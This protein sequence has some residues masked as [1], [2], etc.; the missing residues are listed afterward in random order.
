MA[1]I[2]YNAFLS[3]VVVGLCTNKVYSNYPMNVTNQPI[4][5]YERHLP[6]QQL[7]CI[8]MIMSESELHY[9]QSGYEEICGTFFI[10][11]PDQLISIE[12]ENTTADCDNG[13]TIQVVDGWLTKDNFLPG[14]YDHH[15]PT[16]SRI[17]DYCERRGEDGRFSFTSSQN[18]ALVQFRV[19]PGSEVSI[20]FGKTSADPP[21]CNIVS[22]TSYGDHIMRSVRGRNC[23]FSMIQPTLLIITRI[24]ILPNQKYTNSS[25]VVPYV[26]ILKGETFD[27]NDMNVVAE[28]TRPTVSDEVL[29]FTL[30]GSHA[31]VRMTS[32]GHQDNEIWFSYSRI[33]EPSQF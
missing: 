7:E 30:F 23:T 33:S 8:D 24:R 25:F 4:P 32:Y 14:I 19:F 1:S 31:A 10:A 13:E 28:F 2:L 16:R 18:V 15:L 21:L 22:P 11:Q 5:T 6:P 26:Q 17:W 12:I 9:Q 20:N 29:K 3:V 27:S